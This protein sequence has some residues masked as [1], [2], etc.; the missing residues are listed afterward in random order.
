MEFT[1][2]IKEE[3]EGDDRV[4]KAR[5]PNSVTRTCRNHG[6]MEGTCALFSR[7]P[8]LFPSPRNNKSKGGNEATAS[9]SQTGRNDDDDDDE[10]SLGKVLTYEISTCCTDPSVPAALPPTNDP[11]KETTEAVLSGLVKLDNFHDDN[12]AGITHAPVPTKS[13][14]TNGRAGRGRPGSSHV[15][16][17]YLATSNA[18]NTKKSLSIET[19]NLAPLSN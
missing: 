19:V 8:F 7:I 9:A 2:R 10:A 17:T 16:P 15:P 11:G 3:E 6:W 13:P 4:G 14:T 12:D 5:C 18:K 1:V